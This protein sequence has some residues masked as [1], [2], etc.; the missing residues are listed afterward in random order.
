MT[1]VTTHLAQIRDIV[2]RFIPHVVATPTEE[3]I[4]ADLLLHAHGLPDI[5]MVP[6][7]AA[8]AAEEALAKLLEKQ[9]GM[10]SSAL[11]ASKHFIGSQGPITQTT[12]P[13]SHNTA[14][15]SHVDSHHKLKR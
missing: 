9:A 6:T 14:A 5:A 4:M 11:V 15:T 2:D 8:L 3:A 1:D 12:L 13:T 10:H 7:H